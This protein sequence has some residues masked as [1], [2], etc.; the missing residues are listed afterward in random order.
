VCTPDIVYRSVHATF[1]AG[2]EGIVYSPNYAGMNLSNLEGGAR[3]LDEL[4]FGGGTA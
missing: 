1:R 3:A 2:G 4:G